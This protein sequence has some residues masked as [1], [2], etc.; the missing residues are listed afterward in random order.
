M[1]RNSRWTMITVKGSTVSFNNATFNGPADLS[2]SELTGIMLDLAGV[3]SE[4]VDRGVVAVDDGTGLTDKQLAKLLDNPSVSG[5]VRVLLV[6]HVRCGL[7]PRA[8][9]LKFKW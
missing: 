3:E 1:L 2:M 7:S 5:P 6:V 9:S 4:P 8:C